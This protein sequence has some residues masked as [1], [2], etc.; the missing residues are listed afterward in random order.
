VTRNE[1]RAAGDAGGARRVGL[2]G[3]V[4]AERGAPAPCGAP[5]YRLHPSLELFLASDGHAYLLRPGAG[6]EYVIRGP[7]RADRTLLRRLTRGGV[8]VSDGSRAAE[9]LAPLIRAG[10]AIPESTSAPLDAED[11]ERFS[12]Q[13][14]YLAELGDARDIQRRLRH[15]R[16]TVLGLGGLGTWTLGALASAGV[17]RFV[18]IDDDVVG[19]SNLNR[20][21]IYRRGDVGVTKVSR[22]AA[23]LSAFDPRVECRAH[24][25]LLRTPGRLARLVDDSDAL[26]LAADWPPYE[27]ARWTNTVC[28]EAR[29]PWISAGQQPPLLKIGPT[30]IPGCGACFRCHE[31]QL[32]RDFPLYKELADHR[33][34]HPPRATTFGPASGLIGTLMALELFHLLTGDRPPATHDRALFI[35]MQ[36]LETRWE[37]IERNPECPVCAAAPGS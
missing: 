34:R 5:R 19:L 27:L 4:T 21:V 1:H 14:P 3:R 8:A 10:V 7:D 18:L 24:R 31:H 22:A 25:T 36:T 2:Q 9:R 12:R 33:R 15:S 17:R 32:R 20:Q 16:V 6:Q 13:L 29:I 11:E 35:D 30:F 26:V 37:A 23:W 28:M